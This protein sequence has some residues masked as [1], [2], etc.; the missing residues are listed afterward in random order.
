MAV[1][2]SI[3]VKQNSQSVDNNTSSVTVSASV[4][5]TYGS[6][7]AYD[8][9]IGS[10][11][12]DGTT[13]DFYGM[14][15]NENHTTSGSQVVMTKTVT[16]KHADDGTK[17]LNC[18]ASFHTEINYGII[19]ASS[20]TALTTIPRASDFTVE[21]GVLGVKHSIKVTKKNSA[22]THGIYYNCGSVRQ[23]LICEWNTSSETVEFTLPIDLAWEAVNGTN[24]L[25][26]FYL[27]TYDSS[28]TP[29]GGMVI[30]YAWM[31]IP[32]SVKPSCTITV[33]DPTGYADEFGAFIQ[34]QSKMAIKVTPILAYGSEITSGLILAEGN[35][36]TALEATTPLIQSTGSVEVYAD[37]TDTRGRLGSNTTTINVLSY[38]KPVITQLTV[39]RCDEDGTE[40]ARGMFAKV[41]YGYTID[42]VNGKNGMSGYIQYKKTTETEYTSVGLETALAVDGGTFIFAA[43]DDFA[44]DVQL[45]IA[46][47]FVSVG[48]RTTVSTAFTLIHYANSGKGITF[49]GINS[50]DGVH[51][52][53]IPFTIDGV[54]VDYIVEQGESDG[55][56]YRKWNGGFAECWKVYYGTGI[57]S[58]KNNYSGFYYSETIAVPFPFTFTNLPTV[59][60]DGGSVNYMNFVRTFGKYSDKASFSVVSLMDAGSIDVT[61]DIKAIGK[62]K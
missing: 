11:T 20:S 47:S 37:V 62:W 55:W 38:V 33:T 39:H 6:W 26:A 54:E 27:Q 14:S 48:H 35:K 60:V 40:N 30:K 50:D 41:T 36:Y 25:V 17:I 59:T 52:V 58:A 32:E 53:S 16:V 8:Q 7:N 19:S 13:Y 5:W 31:T 10:L 46:D 23:Q 4:H 15:F 2:L 61:V 22:L 29:I 44:Y 45:L 57:T 12:I 24:V 1:S 28:A 21:D 18:S 3:A 56:F 51:I 49:G 34:G 9:C 43:D 42:T